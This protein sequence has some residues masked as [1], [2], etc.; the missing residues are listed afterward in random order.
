MKEAWERSKAD[1]IAQMKYEHSR[2][3][4]TIDELRK[5]MDKQELQL[6]LTTSKGMT[7]S[8]N[9]KELQNRSEEL[10]RVVEKC[11]RQ[12]TMIQELK[13]DRTVVEEIFNN[14]WATI[15]KAQVELDQKTN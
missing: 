9:I 12:V 8:N 5:N 4:D 7:N 11:Q 3:L 6:N 2:Q 1:F 10:H 13:Q 15:H 14:I